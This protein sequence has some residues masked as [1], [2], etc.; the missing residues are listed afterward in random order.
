MLINIFVEKLLEFAITKFMNGELEL[1]KLY[2]GESDD[3]LWLSSSNRVRST[4]Y[5]N[6]SRGS[7]DLRADVW[8][9]LFC[10][11]IALG[12]LYIMYRGILKRLCRLLFGALCMPIA[13]IVILII[14]VSVN[15]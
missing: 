8:S 10:M 3:N 1:S 2:G 6:I 7:V 15:S 13:F 4:Q 5:H 12:V 11:L 9:A 14:A